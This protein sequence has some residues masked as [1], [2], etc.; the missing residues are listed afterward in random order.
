[1]DLLVVAAASHMTVVVVAT[2]P[3]AAEMAAAH[4]TLAAA[5]VAVAIWTKVAIIA[6]HWHVI[7]QVK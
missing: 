2:A 4:L 3:E 6:Q 7:C 1:M 5:H